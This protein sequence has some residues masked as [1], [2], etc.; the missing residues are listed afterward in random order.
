[1]EN[2]QQQHGDKD[3]YNGRQAKKARFDCEAG[4]NVARRH[5]QLPTI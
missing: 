2:R 1:V 5:E 4:T 3:E